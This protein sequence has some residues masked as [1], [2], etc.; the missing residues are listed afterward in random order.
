M[1]E[2]QSAPQRLLIS[3]SELVPKAISAGRGLSGLWWTLLIAGCDSSIAGVWRSDQSSTASLLA[4]LRSGVSKID[5]AKA[6]QEAMKETLR[7][8]EYRHPYFWA[9]FVLSGR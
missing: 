1:L 7:K 9:G 5:E 8:P 6:L 2:W 4:T 3:S